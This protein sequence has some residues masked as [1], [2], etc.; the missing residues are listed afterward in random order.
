MQC[1]WLLRAPLLKEAEEAI[2]M[3][4]ALGLKV[5]ITEFDITVLPSGNMGADIAATEAPTPTS[6]PY[7]AGLPRR[8]FPKV[9]RLLRAD[10]RHVFAP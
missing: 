6:N 4:A 5:M 10:F 7:T 3:Y 1:H 9:S 2:K 8:C